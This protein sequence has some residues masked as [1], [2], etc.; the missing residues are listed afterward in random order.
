M[1]PRTGRN[2]VSKADEAASRRKEEV[3]RETGGRSRVSKAGDISRKI[4]T[5]NAPASPSGRSRV[6]KSHDIARKIGEENRTADAVSARRRPESKADEVMRKI[7]SNPA[8]VPAERI[9]RGPQIP[10]PSRS[11]PIPTPGKKNSGCCLLP[12]VFGV[13]SIAGIIALIF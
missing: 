7:P 5:D 12:F 8:P 10:Q 3:I 6:S 1:K 9:D 2:R 13:L 4:P 11:I